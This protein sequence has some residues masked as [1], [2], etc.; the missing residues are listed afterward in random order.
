MTELI[1]A[2]GVFVAF[3]VVVYIIQVITVKAQIKILKQIRELRK[4]KDNYD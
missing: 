2:A 3:A 1:I 4:P